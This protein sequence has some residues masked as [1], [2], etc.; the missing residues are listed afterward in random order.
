MTLIP[1]CQRVT[2]VRG[3]GCLTDLGKSV[4]ENRRWRL[5]LGKRLQ[6]RGTRYRDRQ[7]RFPRLNCEIP[8]SVKHP[9]PG[10][11][12]RQRKNPSGPVNR[13]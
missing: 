1:I 10:W 5:R 11:R 2:P 4:P 6:T 9:E 13:E 7:R 3:R 12:T 8:R